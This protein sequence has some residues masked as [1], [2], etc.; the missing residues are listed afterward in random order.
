ML[1]RQDSNCY[2]GR[3]MDKS[4]GMKNNQSKEDNKKDLAN[5]RT[6]DS[7]VWKSIYIESHELTFVENQKDSLYRAINMENISYAFKLIKLMRK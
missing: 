3:T 6:N 1:Q 4:V 5:H 7:T 2:A